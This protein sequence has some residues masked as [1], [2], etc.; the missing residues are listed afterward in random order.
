MSNSI[1]I[2]ENGFVFTGDRQ[3][4]AGRL[5]II[6]KNG[7]II[8]I[9]TRAEALKAFYSN[10]EVID[11]AGKIILPGFVDAHHTGE[12]FILRYLTYGQQVS[13]WNK[14]TTISRVYKYLLTEATFKEFLTL[15]RLSYYAAL[16]SGVTTLAEYG[17]DTPEHSFAAS[18]EALHQTNLKGFIGLHNGDQIE[19]ARKLQ[20]SSIRFAF[21]ISDEE[22]L[23]LYNLQSTIHFARE[24]KWP[25]I[26]HLG[27]TRHACDIVKKNFNKSIAQLIAEYRAI[28]SA[29]H[30]LHLSC[31]DDGDFEII[32]KSHV[33]LVYSPSAIFHK[34]S[35]IPPFGQL[36]KH[37]IT[38]ALGTD[39]GIAQPLENIQS[40]CS[41]VKT[42]G[43]PHGR[44]YSR[45]ALHA[46]NG[47][48]ALGLDK[49]IG[50]IET[51]KKA[52]I[53]FLNL[54]EFRMNSI[55]AD[56]NAEQIL[57]VL[58]Q[59]GSSRQVSDV[60]IH[61]EFYVRQGHILTYS[62]EDLAREGQEIFKRLLLF[63]DK[64]TE[65]LTPP[66][67][68]LPFSE[69]QKDNSKTIAGNMNVEEGFKVVRKEKV[70]FTPLV[71][72]A[73]SQESEKKPVKNIKKIF[74]DEDI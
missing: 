73:S 32:A 60:M 34:G 26:M 46:K 18:L 23:T 58:L 52:D 45:L 11:A 33:P 48:I 37:K 50:T 2:I 27:Q 10:A 3:N 22:N 65:T 15:Y 30:L 43:L 59:E 31:F 6:V 5:T 7:R 28:D 35:D 56:D 21:V 47:A 17:I 9:G 16:K 41:M 40:Y 19:A 71:K 70:T 29:V 53:V 72:T 49:E 69:Y 24:L 25:I 44:A 63:R 61:G 20:K 62:E 64:E 12:S 57:D 1:K 38:L 14:N 4:R 39:W 74:G 66:A 8:E 51:G 36:L 42:L 54:S 67:A 55:L 68:I 13:R